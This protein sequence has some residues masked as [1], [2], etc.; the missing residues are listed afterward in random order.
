MII[1]VNK[2]EAYTYYLILKETKIMSGRLKPLHLYKS[3]VTQLPVLT[4]SHRAEIITSERTSHSF[5][6]DL[7]LF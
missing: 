2:G 6:T 1:T 5:T 7:L 3:D 4:R